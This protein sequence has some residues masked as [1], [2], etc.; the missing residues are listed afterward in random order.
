MNLSACFE[1]EISKARA[2]F[3]DEDTKKAAVAAFLT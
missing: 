1:I 3:K 2:F